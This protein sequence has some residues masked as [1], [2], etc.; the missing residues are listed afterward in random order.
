MRAGH[1]SLDAVI[2]RADVLARERAFTDPAT[3]EVLIR[4]GAQPTSKPVFTWLA[5]L[6]STTASAPQQG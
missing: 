3:P 1:H 2:D 6:T 5:S 4:F